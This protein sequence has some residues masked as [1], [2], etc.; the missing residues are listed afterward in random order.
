MSFLNQT[1][2]EYLPEPDP[3]PVEAPFFV[4]N[5]YFY[6][7]TNAGSGTCLDVN[8]ATNH[9]V[10][11]KSNN[12]S[13]SQQ[14]QLRIL[15]NGY[16]HIVNRALSLALNDPTAGESTATTNV[17]S[18]LNLAVADSTDTRQLWQLVKQ[19]GNRYNLNN[20]NSNHTA[21]LS[22]GSNADGT[23]VLSYT[24]DG[25][26]SQSN[27]R[28]W[29]IAYADSIQDIAD[30]INMMPAPDESID[31]A[32]AY[33]PADAWLHFGADDLSAMTFTVAI[34]DQQGRRVM[35]FRANEG[36][37]LSTLPRGLYIVTW[38][39]NG[40]RHSVKLQR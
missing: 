12:S 9:A 30:N 4:K 24:N 29:Y 11:N 1:F 25:R 34:F 14:W 13:E 37:R 17:G 8:T 27:N 35:E 18:Q 3:E 21:N 36:A 20:A 22:G 2:S 23:S 16:Y 15:S 32:L 33:D 6:T 39:F 19:D 5:H 10:G 26:N 7:I 31:Y 28:L 40:R 38:A